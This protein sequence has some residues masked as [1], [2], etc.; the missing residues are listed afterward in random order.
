MRRLCPLA[1]FMRTSG[2]VIR[3]GTWAV[4]GVESGLPLSIH[5]STSAGALP[6]LFRRTVTSPFAAGN[7]TRVPAIT[8][9]ALAVPT[10]AESTI[11][12][13][14]IAQSRLFIAVL[15]SGNAG[16]RELRQMGAPPPVP[17]GGVPVAAYRWVRVKLTDEVTR[18]AEVAALVA[19]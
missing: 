5:A 11:K 7:T 6:S 15:R 4:S 3:N 8:T 14:P 19:T 17:G 2:G 13:A 1:G 10:T 18:P 12:A 9:L 16:C